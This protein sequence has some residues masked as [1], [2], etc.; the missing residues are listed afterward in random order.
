M[1]FYKSL[2]LTDRFFYF[3]G[4]TIFVFFASFLIQPFFYVGLSL[5]TFC[6][7]LLGADLF[8]LFKETAISVERTNPAVFSLSDKNKVS[9]SVKNRSSLDLKL[10]IID[11]IPYQFRERDFSILTSLKEGKTETINYYL[12]PIVRG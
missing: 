6:F 11:E 10:K 3:L 12:K 2:Y 8:L 4:V 5:L 9:L 7:V 1:R